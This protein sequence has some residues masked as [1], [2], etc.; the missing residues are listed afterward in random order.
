M[1]FLLLAALFVSALAGQTG[2]NVLL[3]VNANSQVSQEIGEYYQRRR[4]VPKANL[5]RIR[6]PAKETIDR[7]TYDS[8]V[9]QP[10]RACL[11]AHPNPEQILYLVTTKGVP[12][13][14]S[15]PM[16]KMKSEA[17]A[18]DSE[19]TLLYA[20][21]RGQSFDIVG[22]VNNPY[23]GKYFADFDAVKHQFYPVTRLT[24]YDLQDV[25]RLIDRSLSA[26]NQGLFVLDM[27][28]IKEME[29]EQW[30][31]VAARA[32]PADRVK[33]EATNAA[34]YG[35][36]GV[37]G[38]AGWG[39]N[40]PQRIADGRRDL[41]MEWLP[42][43]IATEYVST[44]GRTFQRPPESWTIGAWSNK[45]GYFAGA[46]QSLTADF[47]SQGASGASGHVWEPFLIGTPRPN[48]L[49]PAYYSGK[50]LAESFYVAIPFLSWM[51]VVVGDP[52]CALGK[53]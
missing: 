2:A 15:G 40:D 5:C 38:Y 45:T 6:T 22:P 9:E 20:K 35:V 14:V 34:I 41:G 16:P 21:M 43:A 24:G 23:F 29:G 39:S 25:R 19:L 32:L 36:K 47:I 51:N 31:K 49:F 1:R 10:V 7:A 50:N 12:L 17:A 8:D 37:I 18:V 42:G 30:L 13:R 46:P 52:L 44:D 11:E 28:L 27:A 3:I 33:L 26:R 4:N 48:Y 53:P